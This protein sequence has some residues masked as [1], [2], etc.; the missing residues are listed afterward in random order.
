MLLVQVEAQA[1]AP[2]LAHKLFH[3]QSPS[4]IYQLGSY[5]YQLAEELLLVLPVLLGLLH[6]ELLHPELGLL[7]RLR[8]ELLHPE[9]GLL[10]RLRLEL[11][12]PELGLLGLDLRR[13]LLVLLGILRLEP[14]HLD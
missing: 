9:L 4:H 14:R 8:L 5:S 7:G 13:L 6:L 1:Q 3:P 11:L 10:G 2:F 12:H